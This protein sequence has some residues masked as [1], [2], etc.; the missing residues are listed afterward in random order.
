[1][2]RTLHEF[3]HV[4]VII[5][6]IRAR[7]IYSYYMYK[8]YYITNRLLRR[9]LLIA[10]RVC[11]CNMTFTVIIAAAKMHKQGRRGELVVL[12]VPVSVEVVHLHRRG[13]P[14]SPRGTVTLYTHSRSGHPAGRFPRLV[15]LI[16]PTGLTTYFLA[17]C[18]HPS[19]CI[20]SCTSC[21][22]RFA[23]CASRPCRV[24]VRGRMHKSQ[25][26]AGTTECFVAFG[27]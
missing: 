5:V 24:V 22:S 4:Y 9:I 15:R 20:F 8:L 23:W 26:C 17:S 12:R 27:M 7:C 1:M 10:N 6:E 11:R 3:F 14:R 13:H 25:C 2:H 18:R 21:A 19:H 16:S